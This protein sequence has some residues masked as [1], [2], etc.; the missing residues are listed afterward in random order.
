MNRYL[1]NIVARTLG[2]APVVEPRLASVFEPFARG[3]GINASFSDEAGARPQENRSRGTEPPIETDHGGDNL[4]RPP[5]DS[6]HEPTTPRNSSRSS[7]VERSSRLVNHFRGGLFAIDDGG[8]RASAVIRDEAK[9]NREPD[10]DS[11][12]GSECYAKGDGLQGMTAPMMHERLPV[13]GIVV[14]SDAVRFH[15][16]RDQDAAVAG[17]SAGKP[18]EPRVFEDQKP[19][20]RITI[21]RVDV[22]AIMT[23]QPVSRPVRTEPKAFVTLNEYLKRRDG[24][25]R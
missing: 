13:S 18:L 5:T 23:A 14:K 22:R 7:A 1:E 17:I 2:S 8:V 10:S 6:T 25:G 12:L 24:G 9:E 21:G 19:T 20:I 3:E 11:R 4:R 16:G 15:N